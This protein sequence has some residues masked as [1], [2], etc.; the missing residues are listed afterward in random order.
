MPNFLVMCKTMC[1]S[2]CKSIAKLCV[3]FCGFPTPSATQCG[4]PHNS[5]PL[6]TFFPPLS[7]IYSTSIPPQSFPQFHTPYYDYYK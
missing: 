2:S 3:N 6:F 1:K 5:T 7:H 4:F